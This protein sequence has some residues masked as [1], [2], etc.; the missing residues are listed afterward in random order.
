MADWIVSPTTEPR[1]FPRVEHRHANGTMPAVRDHIPTQL[2]GLGDPR[3][4]RWSWQCR[5]GE[6][7]TQERPVR[8]K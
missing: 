4:E 5:C 2:Q 7:W 6:V 8:S 1:G 3:R